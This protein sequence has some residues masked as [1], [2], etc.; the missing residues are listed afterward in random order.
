MTAHAFPFAANHADVQARIEA[1]A[2]AVGRAAGDIQLIAV[3]KQQP[4]DRLVAALDAGQRV[5][6]ENRVQEAKTKFPALR[7]RYAGIE[8]H[9]IGPLQT[10]KV[11][12]AVAL[13]DVIQTL[14]RPKLAAALAAEGRKVGRLPRLLVEVN[15]GEEAQKAGIA[16]R[17]LDAFLA[18]CR[19]THGLAIDGLM[20]I[21]PV[22]ADP[23]PYFALLTDL[24]RRQGLKEVSMGMSA[25]Y[26][27]AV[28]MGATMVRPGSA[29]FGDRLPA[30]AHA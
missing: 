3:S 28:R 6:G 23:T 2:A 7:E 25:D 12:E 8:L 29:L 19:D 4:L 16:P 15:V 11:K 10:N 22:H 30:A 21:P 24:V 17:D 13:F 9:L 1:A 5:F 27:L 14:D 18:E 20:C 26:A